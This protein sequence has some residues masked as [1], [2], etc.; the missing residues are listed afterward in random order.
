MQVIVIGVPFDYKGFKILIQN[1]GN[2]FQA[3]MFDTKDGNYYQTHN[4][5]SFEEGRNRFTTKQLQNAH[6]FMT[7][8]AVATCELIL[9]KDDPDSEE[10]KKAEAEVLKSKGGKELLE[11]IRQVDKKKEEKKLLN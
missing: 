10:F 2:V 9:S 8:Q 1:I 6:K 3:V 5:I 11:Y 4:T 7:A